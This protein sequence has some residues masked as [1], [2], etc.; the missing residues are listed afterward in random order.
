[1]MEDEFGKIVVKRENEHD[2]LRIK[3]TYN[4]D[5]TVTFD[6]KEYRAKVIELFDEDLKLVTTPAKNDLFEYKKD[7]PLVNEKKKKEIS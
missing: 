5:G 6:K 2:F 7:S 1:M 4:N 3:I